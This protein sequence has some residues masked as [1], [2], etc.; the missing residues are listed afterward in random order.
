MM[1]TNNILSPANGKPIIVPSQDIVLGICIT[2]ERE[3]EP[4]GMVFG[5]M[6]EIPRPRRGRRDPAQRVKARLHT[7]DETGAGWS[8][9][10]RPPRRMLLSEILPQS[11]DVPFSLINRVL[12]KDIRTS[13]TWSIACGQKG[14]R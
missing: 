1:S 9:S 2:M 8:G 13:S 11:K 10:S 6:G 12:T 5:D 7:V 3:G 14:R 4:G